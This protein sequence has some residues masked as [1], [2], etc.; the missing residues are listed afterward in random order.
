LSIDRLPPQ[1][2]EAEQ[3]VL[4]ALLIDRDAVIE[5]ADFLRP[6]D[7]YRQAHATIYE[8]ILELYERREPVDIVTVSEVLTRHEALDQI[9][10][11]AYLTSLINLT[12][13]AVN[14]IHYGRIVERKGIQRNLIAAAGRIAAV[15]YE[16]TADVTTQIDKAEQELFAVSQKRVEAGF[17]P[18]KQLLHSAY[19]RLDYLHQHKGEISGVRT[20]FR[21]LDTLTSG[22]QKSDLILIAARPSVGKT[23]L[24]LNIAE[25]ASVIERKTVGL[26]SL[27]M[28]KEQLVLRLLSSVSGI[29][30]QRLQSG[31]LEER[32]FVHMAR[33]FNT[34]AEAPVYIDDT[35][36]ISTMELRTKARRLQAEAGLDLIVVDYLQLMQSS[37]NLRESNR[38]QE[39][40]EISRGLKALARELSVP[41]I[42]LSQLSRQPEMRQ[43]REPR[44]SDLRESGE[45]EQSADLVMF[46]WREKERDQD[47][48]PEGEV[49][50]LR[51]AKHRNG[52]TGETK[53]YFRKRQTRFV[54]YADEGELAG[55][56][57]N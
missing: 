16:D 20:G 2:I 30:S 51:L 32:D 7:F 21:D 5:V 13:T 22:L 6:A 42:A 26:F 12:P 18:L 24:G 14:A 17:T 41:V 29:D 3:S 52:P 57:V 19:D 15:G 49:I 45:L 31:F 44:L 36:N 46:L 50:N 47:E 39:V 35:P 10:G 34:L 53:L 8:A 43:E 23:S 56:Y 27:E 1:S 54:S 40:G 48:D 37:L 11:S 33:H 55:A 25:H 28:S 4:G 38:V 9:G